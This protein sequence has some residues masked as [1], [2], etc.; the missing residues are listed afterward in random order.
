MSNVLHDD[1]WL[2]LRPLSS[3]TREYF[4]HTSN[5]VYN[6]L[7]FQRHH[8]RTLPHKMKNV[9]KTENKMNEVI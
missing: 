3:P 4:P 8:T 7:D 9:E 6:P 2:Q 5:D 1:R